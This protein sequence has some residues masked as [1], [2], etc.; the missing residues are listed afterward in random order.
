MS[1]RVDFRNNPRDKALKSVLKEPI[2]FT[3]KTLARVTGHTIHQV[4]YRMRR[5][6]GYTMEDRRGLSVRAK[7]MLAKLDAM[8]K[9]CQIG[10]R[11]R[12]E[13]R[14]NRSACR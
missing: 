4:G 9:E 14:F 12:V 13:P 1:E 10:R 2:P 11:A 8:I 3:Y 6:R 7:F 5:L